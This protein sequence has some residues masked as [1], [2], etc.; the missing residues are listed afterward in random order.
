[1]IDHLE[2]FRQML[3]IRRFEERLLELFSLGKLFGTTHT[4]IGQEAIAVGVLNHF[5]KKDIVV[6]NH[7]CHGH[8]I[9]FTG[10]IIGLL[11]EIMGKE[12]GVCKGRGGSQHLH[13]GNFFSNGVQ[14]NM[15][16]VAAGMAYA[17]KEKS[18][19]A[20]LVIFIGDG[21]FGEGV[22]Y[23]TLNLVSLWKIPMLIV[24]ENNRYAQST[25]IDNNFAGSFSGRAAAFNIPFGE[26]ETND[27]ETITN[28]FET[29]VKKIRKEGCAH[30]EVIHTYRLASHSKSDDYRDLGE[31]EK[32]KQK[33]PITLMRKK[34]KGIN[35]EEI[36]EGVNDTIYKAEQIASKMGDAKIN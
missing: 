32:W 9:A 16:P 21:T 5:N 33:D 1:M 35:L 8:Y 19:D 22:V 2:L 12:G 3:L 26:I 30:M 7:R 4:C 24:V 14:G 29:V 15:F 25:S 17:E 23:E 36:E 18:S 11:A 10:D 34:L 31:I 28:R 27:L 13:N 6:S 20:I